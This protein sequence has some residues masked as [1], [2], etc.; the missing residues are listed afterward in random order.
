MSSRAYEARRGDVCVYFARPAAKSRRARLFTLPQ[1]M[2]GSSILARPVKIPQKYCVFLREPY[3]GGCRA[4]RGGRVVKVGAARAGQ[5]FRLLFSIACHGL[6]GARS[7]AA[8]GH[9]FCPQWQKPQF[10]ARAH[11]TVVMRITRGSPPCTGEA[12]IRAKITR[13][14]RVSLR[15]RPTFAHTCAFAEK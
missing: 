4:E 11:H 14:R 15:P 6:G 9:G 2:H 3:S 10:A 5:P 8:S 1:K 12:R 13:A 7:D